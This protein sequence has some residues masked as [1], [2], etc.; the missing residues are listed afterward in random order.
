[1][2]LGVLCILTT[3]LFVAH[4]K[5][6]TNGII[7]EGAD[8]S[9]TLD[10][11]SST[12]LP[13]ETDARMISW[14]ANELLFKELTTVPP[15]LLA[16]LASVQDRFTVWYSNQLEHLDV[17]SP[18]PQQMILLDEVID[19][20][21]IWYANQMR[22]IPINPITADIQQI[23][24]EVE[25]RIIIW[26]A[27]ENQYDELVYPHGLISD[28]APPLITNV[29]GIR[30]SS[31]SWLLTWSTNEFADSTVVYGLL[32]GTYTLSENNP[33]Y[34]NDHSVLLENLDIGEI[35]YYRVRSTDLNGNTAQ[36]PEMSFTVEITS[37]PTVTGIV[38]NSAFNNTT[39]QITNLSGTGFYADATVLLRRIGESDI[40]AINVNVINA[41]Q[42]TCDLD[43]TEA[44][45][46]FWDVVV[47]N[48]DGQS[49]ILPEG[50][51]VLTNF[52]P[53]DP[54][55][56]QQ[57]GLE[58]IN[59]LEAWPYSRGDPDVLI[60]VIDTGLDFSHV[61]TSGFR[62][63]T[64]SDY[65]YVN[66]DTVAFDDEGHGTHVTGIATANTNNGYGIAGL[67]PDCSVLPL[68]VLNS[69][70]KGNWEDLATAIRYATDTGADVINLSLGSSSCSPD[71]AD[72]INYAYNHDVT[73]VAASGNACAVK[74][75]LG[76]E[77]FD[78]NYPA[79]F[80]R[81][82]A[83]AAA[84]HFDNRA[85]FSCFGPEVD[86][87]A[88]GVQ[89]LSTY[90]SGGYKKLDGTSM[91][92][93]MVSGLS[94]LLLSQEPSLTPAQIQNILEISADD[95]AGSGW[96]EGTGWGRINASEALQT[97]VGIVAPVPPITCP[98]ITTDNILSLNMTRAENLVSLYA[99]VRDEVFL[100]SHIGKRYV[101]YY[102]NYGP[103]L[104]GILVT[105]TDLRSRTA[106]F[107]EHASEE[108]ESLLPGSTT[109][110]T[111]TQ[112]LYDEG[113]LL[114]H[115]LAAAGSDEFGEAMLQ[116]WQDLALVEDIG[117]EPTE[118]W[119]ELR[120]FPVYLPLNI[121]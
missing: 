61:D 117:E 101:S 11:I 29:S 31:T 54:L 73:I 78:V 24:S 71:V 21:K 74:V 36:S 41:S 68:K 99:Q 106:L 85:H 5:G 65:D 87:A 66:D 57:W 94:G 15:S 80:S 38:P 86:L 79:K 23:L 48:M 84:G 42:I 4:V 43:L 100:E 90:P 97:T 96:D 50:F 1:M 2:L 19:R 47:T 9:L 103:E 112:E 121:R 32:P 3:L 81:V 75:A 95:V 119:E 93:P 91:A 16:D 27:N 108:F 59:I 28:S 69:A 40:F 58:K 14:Y 60:A 63:F 17:L 120:S 110:I 49:G 92:A 7:I 12:W 37:P 55:F 107:L 33:L 118:I 114:V 89:I 116:V 44:Q 113:E 8:E 67:C 13:G 115:D 10:V 18:S 77:T 25:D 70:G 64:D 76:E 30:A 20:Y 35:Y 88:P 34:V 104:A 39:V 62:V 105:D 72:A 45:D 82:I 83:V 102:S 22:Y 98:T 109:M 56:P 53:N 46:G 26:Y 52:V 111:F 6:Q 51:T